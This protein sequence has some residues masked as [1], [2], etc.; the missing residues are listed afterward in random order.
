MSLI[1]FQTAMAALIRRPP[2]NRPEPV[3]AL[4][5][6]CELTAP[7]RN[8]LEQMARIDELNKYAGE[9]S[10]KRW[11]LIERHLV[12]V[13]Q[14]ID[15]DLLYE[16]WLLHYE[17]Q[18]MRITSDMAGGSDF[19]LGFLRFL[20]TDE[21][22]RAMIARQAP[23]FIWDLMAYEQAE[24]EV[25]ALVHRGGIPSAAALVRHNRFRVLR[26]NHDLSALISQT[27]AHGEK[28]SEAPARAVRYVVV[29]EKGRKIPRVFEVD[30]PLAQALSG[31]LKE[32]PDPWPE[33]LDR[34][35]LHA[36]GV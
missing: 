16:L 33:G 35:V 18:A 2:Q 12:R 28:P 23:P 5:A 34:A 4:F 24:I 31:Q 21:E 30:E 29:G 9:L 1:G 14:F 19:S 13:S 10:D 15:Q 11:Q 32:Q 25:S 36:M 22:A 7:E 8:A 17:P 27:R 3:A 26:L 6:G 20:Q